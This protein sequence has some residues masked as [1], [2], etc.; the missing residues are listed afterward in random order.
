MKIYKTILTLLLIL[1]TL[2]LVNCSKI[3]TEKIY[4]KPENKIPQTTKDKS[5]KTQSNNSIVLNTTEDKALDATLFGVKWIKWKLFSENYDNGI[6]LLKE[7]YVYSEND[8]LIRIYHWPPKSSMAQSDITGYL[9]KIAVSDSTIS[10]NDVAFT[11]ENMRIMISE[12]PDK[13]IKITAEYLIFPYMKNLELGPQLHSSLYIEEI[14]FGKI[15]EYL[16][17]N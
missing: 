1:T 7:A 11:Q 4:K 9:N 13:Q 8:K 6:I 2:S 12:T 14:L 5:G 10:F 3:P 17:A 15:K 16:E